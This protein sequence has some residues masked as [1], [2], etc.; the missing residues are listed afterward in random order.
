MTPGST[1]FDWV[2]Y[3]LSF[4]LVICLLLALLWGLKKLQIRSPLMRRPNA[5]VQVIETIVLGTRQKLA[6]VRIDQR[7]VL[8]GV[9][10]QVI[11]TIGEMA[12]APPSDPA[13]SAGTGFRA[14]TEALRGNGATL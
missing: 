8:I 12:D 11:T 5:R 3:L 1:L 9:T 2:Q 7:E 4:A 13:V 10:H 6:L 14:A